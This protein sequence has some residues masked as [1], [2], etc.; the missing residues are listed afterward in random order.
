[1]SSSSGKDFMS[2]SYSSC[3]I[4]RNWSY[5][6]VHIFTSR[7]LEFFVTCLVQSETDCTSKKINEIQENTF[8]L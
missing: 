5:F 2:S 6:I 4:T 7:R 1:M 3:N 8:N